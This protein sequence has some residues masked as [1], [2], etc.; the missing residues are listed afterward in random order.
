MAEGELDNAYLHV[1]PQHTQGANYKSDQ[2]THAAIKTSP[3]ERADS[4]PITK[5][6]ARNPRLASVPGSRERCRPVSTLAVAL[7][8]LSVHGSSAPHSRNFRW[9]HFATDAW[10]QVL[11]HPKLNNR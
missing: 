8:R 9:R 4:T 5:I 1:S 6:D 10:E 2:T 11:G 7:A 3:H